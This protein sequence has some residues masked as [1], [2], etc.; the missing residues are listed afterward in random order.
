MGDVA[1]GTNQTLDGGKWK[2]RGME[3][4]KHVMV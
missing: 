2:M 3:Q 4:V 1:K